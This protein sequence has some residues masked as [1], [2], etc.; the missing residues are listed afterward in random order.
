MPRKRAGKIKHYVEKKAKAVKK[1]TKKFNKKIITILILVGIFGT[2]LF[3]NS[4]FNY[5][6]GLAFD[7]EGQTLGTR[8]FLSGPDPYY[9]MRLCSETLEKGYYPYLSPSEGDPLLNYPVGLYGGA[10]P[11]LFNMIA[12]SSANILSNFMPQ[13]DALGWCM[14]FLPAIY[15]ALLVFP[16]YGIGKELFNRKVGLIAA[17]FTAIIPAH[18]GSG[19]GSS[20]SLFDH[21]S[22][23]LLLFACTFFFF[24]KSL[25]EKDFKKASIS[26]IFAGLFVGAI[27][28]T[29]AAAQVILLLILAFMIVQLILDMFRGMKDI[30]TAY[31]TV[32]VLGVGYLISLPLDFVK[33]YMTTF[34][35]YI[36]LMSLGIL[37]LYL[38]LRKIKL[39]WVI[40]MPALGCLGAGILSFFYMIS[41]GVISM[42]GPLAT[43]ADVIFG[44]GIYG[45]KVSLTIGEAHTFGLSQTVMMLG[46]VLY[47]LALVG[48]ILFLIKSYRNKMKPQNLFFLVVFI[49]DFWMLTVAGRFVNDLI[50]CVVI[51][52]AYISWEILS[53]INYKSMFITIKG[54]G[55]FHGLRK[56]IKYPHILG[57]LFVVFILVLPNSFLALDAATPPSMDEQVFGEGFQGAFGNSLGQQLYWADVCYWLSQQDTDIEDPAERPGVLT[58]WDYGFYLSSMS[59]HPT[60]ADNY[61]SGIPCAANFHTSLSEKEAVAVLIIRLLEGTK[62][63]KGLIGEI[64]K[65]T[66]DIIRDYFPTYTVEENETNITINRAQNLIDILE[67]PEK[68]APSTNSLVAPEYGN[69]ELRVSADNAMYHDATKILTNLSDEE[70]TTL[71]MKI[72]EATGFS[73][74]YYGIETRDMTQIFGVF[75][76]LSDKSTHGYVTMEDDWYETV[77]VDSNTGVEYTEDQLNNLT[78]QQLNEMSITTTTKRKDAFFESMAFKTFYGFTTDNNLPDNRLPTYLLKH[79]RPV[80]I[81]PYVSLAKYYEGANVSGTVKVGNLG[82][83]G[84]VVYVMDEYGIPHDYSM[85]ENGQFNLI[86]PAGNIS[87]SLYIGQNRLDTKHV[88]IVSEEEGRRTQESNYEVNFSV[89]LSSININVEGIPQNDLNLSVESQRFSQYK[90]KETNIGNDTYVFKDLIPDNYNIYI[91]NRTGTQIFGDSIYIQPD[92]NS[93]NISLG[94]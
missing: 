5:T 80:Y 61:Q 17:F 26:A 78:Q 7:P 36:F 45:S 27:Q 20:F 25:K 14:L 31:K 91:T 21:D 51:F 71:Y 39:P 76:F 22:F 55:G 35:L 54:I 41:S 38:I 58:W 11:P 84:S 52:S 89:N 94:D 8:F 88:G 19:H 73:I 4:Y 3:L 77:Y 30:S 72:M 23:L 33:E 2:V 62:E 83:A 68:N 13:M 60:V 1:P 90:F 37:A 16:I 57:V 53:R 93:Y 48:F 56:G 81:S 67:N 87:L 75:P 15:G 32:I 85:I 79:F 18:I 82:Y 70:I 9:N 59:G 12:V 50:P 66:K 43:L 69:T 6:S 28:L 10:R 92:N 47:W 40:T 86:M 49:I 46:P 63:S 29:W 42:R 34:P 44:S 65:E 24:I 74:R 64:P